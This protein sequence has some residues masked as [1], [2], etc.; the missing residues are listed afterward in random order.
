MPKSVSFGQSVITKSDL[1]KNFPD[2]RWAP[3]KSTRKRSGSGDV[4]LEVRSGGSGG[5]SRSSSGALGYGSISGSTGGMHIRTKSD[6][7]FSSAVTDLTKSALVRE[8][9]EGGRIRFQLPKDNF[10]VLMDAS[11]GEWCHIVDISRC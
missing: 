2:P 4:L 6:M 3:N 9:T 5:H 7:S 1:L 10:R 8:V 11:L